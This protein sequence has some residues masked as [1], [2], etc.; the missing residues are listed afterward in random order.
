MVYDVRV[1]GPDG[2]QVLVPTDRE[3]LGGVMYVPPLVRPGEKG[4]FPL[5]Q[6]GFKPLHGPQLEVQLRLVAGE[7]PY[8]HHWTLTWPGATLNHSKE[9]K[10]LPN[11][12]K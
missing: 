3:V 10:T 8:V 4:F 5:D 1:S 6:T 2:A 7:R 12:G 9:R 11:G